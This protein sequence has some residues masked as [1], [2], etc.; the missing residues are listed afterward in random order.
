MI[1]WSILYALGYA[2]IL[3]VFSEMR[4]QYIAADLEI[5]N[6]LLDYL[7]LVV[8][9]FYLKKN[10]SNFYLKFAP[11]KKNIILFGFLIALV[12]CTIATTV[13]WFENQ[14][15]EIPNRLANS[16]RSVTVNGLLA[17]AM[18]FFIAKKLPEN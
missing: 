2:L 6:S 14:S 18:S 16:V 15:N 5:V 17:L 1:K 8:L 4:K 7:A 13:L 10:L 12:G 11:S 9:F 3:I